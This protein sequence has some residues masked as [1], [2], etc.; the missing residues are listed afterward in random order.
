MERYY[1]FLSY[2]LFSRKS[3]G[4]KGSQIAQQGNWPI[5]TILDLRKDFIEVDDNQIGDK[6][7]KFIS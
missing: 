2:I 1:P 6:G 4:V 3:L 5:I 7:A